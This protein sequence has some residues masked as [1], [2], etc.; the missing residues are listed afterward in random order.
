MINP[1]RFLDRARAALAALTVFAAPLVVSE[2]HAGISSCGNIDI[3]ASAECKVE[4]E[5]GCKAHCTPVHFE[6]ACA[7]ECT[8]ECDLPSV[9]CQGSCEADCDGE[10][11][12]DEGSFDCQGTCEADCDGTCE[13]HCSAD[14][15]SAE[16]EGK[17]KATCKA[18]C[19]GS[20]TG[21]PPSAKCDAKCKAKCEGQC[22]ADTNMECKLAC[23]GRCTSELT[24]GCEVQ[25]DKP[26][27][28]VFCDGQYVDQGNNGEECIKAIEA[29]IKAHVDVTARGTA[30]CASNSC[31]AEGSASCKCSAPGR[32]ASGNTIYGAAGLTG[33]LAIAAMARRKRQ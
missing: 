24:G 14:S 6:A 19:S 12:V 15:N 21:T 33:L 30:S 17:C 11:S 2:A 7:G 3:E 4:V 8:G 9:Q 32:R 10:C 13:G 18:E 29:F 28:A 20:C 5:G 1:S 27:G 23:H 16:C 31:E 26:E 22:T 25:C